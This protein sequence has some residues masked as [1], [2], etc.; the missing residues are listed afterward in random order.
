[1][2]A[3]DCSIVIR[4]YNEEK[5]LGRLLS[6]IERQ[7]GV[8]AETILVDSGSTD[9]TVEI[10]SQFPVS[11]LS[12][13]PGEFTFGRSLNLGCSKAKGEFIVLASAHVYPVYPDWLQRLLEPFQEQR[14]ALTYGKQRGSRSTRFSEQQVFAKLFPEH[15]PTRLEHP[16]CNNAN[17]AI[18][19]E[20]WMQRA[21]DEDLPGLEDLEWGAW[22]T[23]QGRQLNYVPEAEVIH[24]HDETPRQVY[25]RY[26]REAIALKRIWPSE[27]FSLAEFVKLY[28][29]NVAT[30]ARQAG[31]QGA[32][33]RELAG[34][35]WFR[36]MQF[37]G[38]YRGFGHRGPLTTEL[39]RAL[40][41][42]QRRQPNRSVEPREVTPLEYGRAL[43]D[44]P[45]S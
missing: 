29:S 38:T 33:V 15:P 35:L 1:M 6:G 36:W 10:A 25:N 45:E 7:V 27:R 12:I 2:S 24:V 30:D 26:K 20:L 14:V 31:R 42:P 22:A 11:V 44:P 8:R 37:W 13:S 34:I 23:A 32:L 43:G 3:P 41:Y 4:A 28:L 19:R 21:Y 5:H 9:Q 16:F 40:Y 17:A 39:K 18:R